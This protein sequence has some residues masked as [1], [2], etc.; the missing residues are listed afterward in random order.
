MHL[1][2]HLLYHGHR[3]DCAAGAGD[4]GDHRATIALDLGNGKRQIPRRRHILET[5]IGEIAAGNLRSAFQQ[6]AETAARAEPL[7]IVHAPVEFMHHRREK[8]RRIGDAAGDH[9]VSA[10]AQRLD[11]GLRAQICLRRDHVRGNRTHRRIVFQNGAAERGDAIGDEAAGDG[12]NLFSLC[13]MLA[14][15][16]N[17]ALCRAVRIDPALIADDSGA[18]PEASGKHS[19]HTI[20][21]IGVIS[22]ERR[23]APL[24]DLR[25]RHG[26]LSHRLETEIVE[27]AALGV[28]FRRLD[29]VTPPRRSRPYPQCRQ[30]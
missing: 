28:E 6:M 4:L 7:E 24:A 13:A 8:Q 20:V 14:Q 3:I 11:D 15:Q 26:R 19:L 10:A 18:A 25:R 22:G 23:I 2:E 16:L 5:G 1:V 21:E 9:D 30:K 29:A 17:N 12:C 27:I